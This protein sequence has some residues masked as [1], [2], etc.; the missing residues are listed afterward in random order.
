M[1][2]K[3]RSIY[4]FKGALCP[5][6]I[7]YES[8]INS[9]SR[10]SDTNDLE[11]DTNN[12][13]PTEQNNNQMEMDDDSS[14]NK[15][16]CICMSTDTDGLMIACDN[17]NEWYHGDCI[18]VK[19]YLSSQINQFYCHLCRM[20]DNSLKIIY[21]DQHEQATQDDKLKFERQN[22]FRQKKEKKLL[23]D[24]KKIEIHS[25]YVPLQPDTATQRIQR[26]CIGPG[27]TNP[28]IDESK[29]CSEK[30]GLELAKIRLI[31]LFPARFKNFNETLS[32]SDEL[33]L[34]K[35]SE[36]NA[37][38]NFSK[39]NLGQL[40][41]MTNYLK[42]TIERAKSATIK[43]NSQK[44]ETDYLVECFTCDD[45]KNESKIYKHMNKCSQKMEMKY[46]LPFKAFKTKQSFIDCNAACGC[47]LP[48][49]QNIMEDSLTEFCLESK[50]ICEIHLD[51]ENKRHANIELQRLRIN[52][53]LTKLTKEKEENEKALRN[54]ANLLSLLFNETINL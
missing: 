44:L 28:A 42:Y 54:R 32:L 41:R 14:T 12:N 47:P 40:D 24:E 22:T 52:T 43:P 5:T 1:Q 8:R 36:I 20:A 6:I 17:C 11:T 21:N 7:N 38:I 2:N 35:I 25:N 18:G 29:Y 37:E 53:K 33:N 27:C 39:E 13:D 34:K 45:Q 26:Q 4:D 15:S 9:D 30:C 51:W 23:N 3:T 16:Y 49:R 10:S 46:A 48:N 31:C 19:K 50:K